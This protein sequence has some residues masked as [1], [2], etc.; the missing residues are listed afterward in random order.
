MT[1]PEVVGA[2]EAAQILGVEVGRI[3]RWRKGGKMPPV[4]AQLK[5]G[6]LWHRRDVELLAKEGRWSGRRPRPVDA[7]GLHEVSELLGG[8]DKS[9][10]G[11]WRREGR[12]PE[13]WLDTRKKGTPWKP[14]RGLAST[15]LWDRRS[16]EAFA[17]SRQTPTAA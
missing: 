14:G 8:V 3:S 16:V 2:Q 13:P 5:S 4:A 6:P 7:L 10:I 11:R 17:A 9:Q 1:R 15:P 12:F